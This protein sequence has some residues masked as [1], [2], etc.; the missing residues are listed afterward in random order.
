[1]TVTKGLDGLV[2][3]AWIAPSAVRKRLAHRSDRSGHSGAATAPLTSLEFENGR[4]LIFLISHP[5]SLSNLSGFSLPVPHLL[6][7]ELVSASAAIGCTPSRSWIRPA[8]LPILS[9][10]SYCIIRDGALYMRPRWAS[11]LGGF[12]VAVLL[13]YLDVG[14]ISRWNFESKGPA[15]PSPT[16]DKAG[17]S[18]TD[19]AASSSST[20][21]TRLLYGWYTLWSFRQV[22]TPHEVKHVPKFSSADPDYVPSQRRF[23]LQQAMSAVV[24]YLLLDL[25]SQRPPPSNPAQLFDPTLVPVFSRLHSVTASEIKVRALTIA[26]FGVTFFLII[27]GFQSFAA[28]LAVGAGLSPVENW[29]PAFGSIW[30]AYSLKN[31]WGYVSQ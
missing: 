21:L 27:Q 17:H 30:D 24:C 3:A 26:G 5:M 20:L 7:F 23:V 25:L 31:V 22:N 8:T 13:R 16:V 10:C 6:L 15:S 12:S 4:C 18:Q 14:L 19:T 28:A 11:L 2:S 9:A 29:R 1:M